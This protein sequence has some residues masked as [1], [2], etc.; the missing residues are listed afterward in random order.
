MNHSHTTASSGS[1][2]AAGARSETKPRLSIVGGV[3]NYVAELNAMLDDAPA[4]RS[5]LV[6]RSPAMTKLVAEAKR[7]ARSNATILL[8]GESGTGKEVMA[9]LIHASSRRAAAP[10][11]QLNCAALSENLIESELFGHEMGAFTGAVRDRVGQFESAHGGTLLLDEISEIPLSIQAKL[12]RVLEA[13]E[14]QKVG[15]TKPVRTNVRII[16]TSNRDLRQEATDGTFRHDLYYR[17]NILPLHVPALRERREDIPALAIHFLEMHR[18]EAQ[19]PI[20]GVDAKAMEQLVA[21]DWPGN[22]RQLRNVIHRACLVNTSGVIEANDLPAIDAVDEKL[23]DS[24]LSLKLEDLERRMICET[25]ERNGNN[26]TL[27]ARQLGVTARTLT[28]KMN[29]YRELGYVA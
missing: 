13:E 29:R 15:S 1:F 7:Y 12:L 17:L 26:K 6:F 22:V 11:A 8:T 4:D 23:P 3:P 20:T 21:A 24:I 5:E 28:N 16:A 2:R 9:R 10:Y 14:F 18:G 27:A 19:V 25:L